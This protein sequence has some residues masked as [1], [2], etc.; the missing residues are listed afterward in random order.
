MPR[1]C[2]PATA[3]ATASLLALNSLASGDGFRADGLG[4]WMRPWH[5]V[6]TTADDPADDECHR[7]GGQQPQC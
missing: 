3:H 4:L 1:S 7:G 2:G 5:L 6:V